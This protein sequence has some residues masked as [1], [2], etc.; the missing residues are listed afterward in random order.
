MGD[1]SGSLHILETPRNLL[2]IIKNEKQI[3]SSFFER[4]SKRMLAAAERK[5]SHL[6][7]RAQY[8]AKMTDKIAVNNL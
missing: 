3:M 8:D 5:S 2:K 6:K 1:D 4:E 7:G